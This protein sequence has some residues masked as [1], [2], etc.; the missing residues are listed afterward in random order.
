MALHRSLISLIIAVIVLVLISQSVGLVSEG[1][2]G[3]RLNTGEVEATGL[4]PGLH[5]RVPFFGRIIGLD[6][7]TILLNSEQLNGGRVKLAAKDGKALEADYMA[8]WR[9]SDTAAFCRATGCDESAGARRINDALTPLLQRAV[10]RQ[11]STDL[12][13]GAD[14]TLLAALPDQLNASLQKLGVS[15]QAVHLTQLALP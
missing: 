1:Q 8:V 11:I 12:L 6:R 9:I 10:A 5:L 13:A 3:V 15:V 2:T 4:A 14:P 7:H